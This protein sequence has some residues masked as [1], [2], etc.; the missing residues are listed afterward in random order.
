MKP[1]NCELYKSDIESTMEYEWINNFAGAKILISGATGMIASTL[2]DI[3][4]Y[5]NQKI[6]EKS[7]IHIIAISRNMES[8]KVRFE[9]YWDSKCFT[10]LSHD[11]TKPLPELGD[12]DYI[13]HAA[14]N[15]HPRAYAT[16]P[17]G[18]ITANVD[19]THQLLEYAANH[20]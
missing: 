6:Q 12:V 10:Y 5:Q 13:L 7:G 11:I 9:R 20:H 8:A 3:L 16:D 15:T 18:T 14:S 4:M 1:Y 2:I 17:I 19:G